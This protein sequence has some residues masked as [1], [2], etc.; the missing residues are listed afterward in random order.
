MNASKHFVTAGRLALLSC[1]LW[2]TAATAQPV[3]PASRPAANHLAGNTS[4]F[5]QQHADNPIAW[6]VWGQEA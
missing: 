5:L 1:L 2:S 4:P 3:N 6:H